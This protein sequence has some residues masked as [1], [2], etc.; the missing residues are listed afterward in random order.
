MKH[1]DLNDD[2]ATFVA[3]ML[4]PEKVTELAANYLRQKAFSRLRGRNG[5]QNALHALQQHL[6]PPQMQEFARMV[7][8][9]SGLDI[10]RPVVRNRRMLQLGELK[11]YEETGGYDHL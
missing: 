4:S 3:G 2:V 9:E 11:H 6:E 5:A 8:E 10:R 7:L 1:I